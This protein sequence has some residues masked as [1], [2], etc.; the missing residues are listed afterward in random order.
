M[1]SKK[2]FYLPDYTTFFIYWSVTISTVLLTVVSILETI[3]FSVG[4]IILSI[5]LI[6]IFLLLIY[7]HTHFYIKICSNQLH[8]HYFYR[9]N[10]IIPIK[11]IKSVTINKHELIITYTNEKQKLQSYSIILYY[12][13]I[14][15]VTTFLKKN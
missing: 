4:T 6:I 9:K 15:A 8:I 13:G 5:L 14:K 12:K 3:D 1:C 7:Y 11:N 10:R 2:Y